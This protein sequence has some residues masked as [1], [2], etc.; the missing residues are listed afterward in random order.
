MPS[1]EC[2]PP[3][4]DTL[5]RIKELAAKQFGGDPQAIDEN[6]PVDQLGID[7]LGFLEH[8]GRHAPILMIPKAV[9]RIAS[10]V[11]L[12]LDIR[13]PYNPHVIP[14]ATRYWF[15]DSTK[16]QRELAVAFRGAR[17]T[18]ASTLDWLQQRAFI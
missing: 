9:A 12:N 7:S 4:M 8:L 15:V 16:A 13:L 3:L 11:A 17:E 2:C 18:I 10:R 6:A 14:Y 5:A 1:R